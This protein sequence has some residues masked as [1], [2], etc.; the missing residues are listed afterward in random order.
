M[1]I[2]NKNIGEILKEARE[3]KN[4]TQKQLADRVGKKRAYISKIEGEKGSNIKVQ[5]LID[6]VENG[7]GGEVLIDWKSLKYDN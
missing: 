4:L 1:K 3:R 6:I 7:L 2:S 5:T